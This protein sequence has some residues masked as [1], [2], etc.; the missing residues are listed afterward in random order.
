M[1]KI[2]IIG[3]KGMLGQELVKTFKKDKD[4]KVIAWDKEDI[5]ISKEKEVSK[6]IGFTKPN[7]IINAAAYN[8]VDKCEESKKEYEIAKKINGLAPG[9]LAASAKKNKAVLVHY[10][11]DYV[12]NGEP[13]IPEPAGCSHSCAS[14][15][16]HQGFQPEVGFDENAKPSPISNYGK[17]KLIGEKEVAKNTKSYYIIR[18]SKL[19]GKPAIGEGAKR[20]FFDV[21]LEAGKKNKEVHPVKSPQ[22]GDAKGVFNRVKAVDEETS[23][24]TYAPDLAKK[25]KEILD[26][27]K[28][29]GIYHIVNSG[30]CTWYEAAVELYRQAK[31]KTKII[32][33][34]GNEFPRPAKRPFYSVLVN[35]KLNPMRS[36]KEALKEYLKSMNKEQ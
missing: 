22:S 25:T 28:P 32:P 29:F 5:D 9:Y 15:S 20:S 4:Y 2:L 13:E 26:A 14:C 8:A 16:L 10:S 17:S 11:T 30:P 36:W 6:K 33:V 3:S 21:M 19:F 12:F 35:T 24:F 27:K 1:Q 34:D 7:I 23:C 31:I 18:L